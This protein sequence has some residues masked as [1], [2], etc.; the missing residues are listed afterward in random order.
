V[1]SLLFLTAAIFTKKTTRV[2]EDPNLCFQLEL[3]CAQQD[4][5]FY[6]LSLKESNV[7]NKDGISSSAS[8]QRG[9]LSSVEEIFS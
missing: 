6:S 1:D 5:D 3:L 9:T 2:D 8:V 4:L 7:S